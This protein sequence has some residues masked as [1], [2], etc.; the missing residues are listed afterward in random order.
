MELDTEPI[1]E[2]EALLQK[3][4][5]TLSRSVPAE[6][7]QTMRPPLPYRELADGALATWEL[8]EW[9]LEL[10]AWELEPMAWELELVA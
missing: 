3:A 6:K 10:V 8:V 1:M 2:Q 7:L 5:T 4:D 9:E